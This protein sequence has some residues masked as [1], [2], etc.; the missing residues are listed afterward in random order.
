MENNSRQTEYFSIGFSADSGRDVDRRPSTQ[1]EE[2]AGARPAPIGE[3]GSFRWTKLYNPCSPT[4]GLF[5]SC[6]RHPDA[7]SIARPGS[8]GISSREP[9]AGSLAATSVANRRATLTKP[10]TLKF[11]SVKR[12]FLSRGDGMRILPSSRP[13][14]GGILRISGSCAMRVRVPLRR[15]DAIVQMVR[16]AHAASTDTRLNGPPCF[17]GDRHGYF[18]WTEAEPCSGD[19]RKH[20]G[21]NAKY[22]G[23]PAGL[24]S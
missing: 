6:R 14:T 8:P 19:S 7:R 1:D 18:I 17:R 15:K 24:F 21:H 5:A 22:P 13:L 20:G 12:A 11:S 23:Q 2:A 3:V 9:Q 16:T 4:S 10:H